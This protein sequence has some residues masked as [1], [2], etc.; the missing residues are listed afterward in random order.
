MKA[1]GFRTI[2]Q[3][4]WVGFAALVLLLLAAG[5]LG[6]SSL[7]AMSH[8]VRLTLARVQQ[9]ASLSTTLLTGVAQTLQAG[10][11]YVDRRDSASL[12]EFRRSGFAAHRVARQL[13]NLGEQTVEEASLVARVDEQLSRLEVALGLAHRLADLGRSE[14]AHE[15]AQST[16]TTVAAV[17]DDMRRLGELKA[18]KV[19][20]AAAKLRTQG[21]VRS[22]GLLVAVVLALACAVVVVITTIRS[23]YRPLELLVAHARRLSEGDLS[24]RT[25]ARMPGEFETLAIAMNQTGE[26]LSKVVEIAAGTADDLASSAHDLSTVSQQI[27]LSANQVA[28]SMSEV[29][30]G[31]EGQVQRLREVD[32]ALKTI[33]ARAEGVLVGAEE[34]GILAGTIEQTA[35]A[36]R[37]EV[38]RALAILTDVR[39]SVQKAAAEVLELDRT[40]ENINKFV[41]S[42]SRVA[43][44]TN[45]LAL[46]AAI[47]AARAGKAGRGFAVVAE[48]VRKLAEQAQAAADDVVQLTALVTAKVKSTSGAMELGAARVNEI[49]KVS[50]E[51]DGALS[52]ISVAAERTR[53]A[54]DSVSLEAQG[55]MA[56]VEVAASGLSAIAQTAE[57]HAAAAQEVSASTEEQSAACEQMTT[58]SESLLAGSTVLKGLVGGLRTA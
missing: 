25:E 20:G 3:R 45:L 10:A 52:S 56:V 13:G 34:V 5:L 39:A 51:M 33:Q 37:Q 21:R 40:A 50:R 30:T 32:Q 12:T 47:E 42:V 55:N 18:A 43:E 14:A 48:E 44:Q 38:G 57:S 49:E 1:L 46:N 31:A 19:D 36:K 29:S 58:A 23:I 17:F 35:T 41:G 24:V 4:L 9:E 6:Y 2:K 15:Q 54:A 53:R 27:T 16:R 28:T 26:S 22:S 7:T 8:D 11:H